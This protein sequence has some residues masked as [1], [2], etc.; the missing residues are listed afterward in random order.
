MSIFNLFSI[1]FGLDTRRGGPNDL[2]SNRSGQYEIVKY[3]IDLGNYDKGHYMII[4]INQQR[5][6]QFKLPQGP[7]L[8]TIIANQRATGLTRNAV[9]FTPSVTG[10]RLAYVDELQIGSIIGQFERPIKRTKKTIALYMPDTVLFDNQQ[11]YSEPSTTGVLP[12]LLSLGKSAV[13]TFTKNNGQGVAQ[14]LMN[15]MGIFA[16]AGI[17][18]GLK[19]LGFDNSFI[20]AAQQSILG[21]V[22]NPLLEVIYTSPQ[23]R[24]FR[25]DF[26]FYPRDER[27]ARSVQNIILD[28]TYHQAPEIVERSSG[29]F[30]VPPSEFDIKFYY[31][32]AINPNIPPISTCVLTD[33]QVDYAPN[34]WTAYETGTDTRSLYPAKGGTGMPVA[35]RMSLNFKE[36]EIVT[37]QQIRALNSSSF[38]NSDP[39][40]SDLY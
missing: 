2:I 14:N 24:S 12:A 9:S 21:A 10:D 36:T 38:T 8:P 17:F 5:E 20:N 37:K 18:A 15:N 3:P 34:G 40:Y 27:E 25:F 33:I 22:T 30:L 6:T 29:F 13:D 39:G 19:Q 1:D 4:H 26:M 31:N 7:D 28:L 35:I 16:G 23:L 32:G 11:S